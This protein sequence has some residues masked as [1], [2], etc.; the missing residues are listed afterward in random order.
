MDLSDGQ[1]DGY[2]RAVPSSTSMRAL[3]LLPLLV[4]LAACD[5]DRPD[6]SFGRF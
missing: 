4:V 2:R 1:W 6:A 5:S 3:L